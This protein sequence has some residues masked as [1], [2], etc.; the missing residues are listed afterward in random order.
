MG[1]KRGRRKPGVV[2]QAHK[3]EPMTYRLSSSAQADDPVTTGISIKF[4]LL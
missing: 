4:H 2:S 3:Y 1:R